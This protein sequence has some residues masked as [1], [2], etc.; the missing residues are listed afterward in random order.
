MRTGQMKGL[1]IHTLEKI[2]CLQRHQESNAVQRNSCRNNSI[3]GMHEV[4]TKQHSEYCKQGG[5]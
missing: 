1:G 4:K 3:K 5:H 2:H